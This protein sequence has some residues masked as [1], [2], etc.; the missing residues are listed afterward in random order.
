MKVD[1]P[2]NIPLAK[3]PLPFPTFKYYITKALQRL[4]LQKLYFSILVNCQSPALPISFGLDTKSHFIRHS[5]TI[6]SP[7]PHPNENPSFCFNHFSLSWVTLACTKAMVHLM[8]VNYAFRVTLYF[9]KSKLGFYEF[10]F[11][12]FLNLKISFGVEK[13]AFKI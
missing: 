11:F 1:P 7:M 4:A 8:I 3:A 12:I 5:F 6:I 13:P 10:C 9:C 2:S